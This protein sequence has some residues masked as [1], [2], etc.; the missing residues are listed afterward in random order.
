LE[1][2]FAVGKMIVMCHNLTIFKIGVHVPPIF[3]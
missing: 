2:T 1:R 3:W